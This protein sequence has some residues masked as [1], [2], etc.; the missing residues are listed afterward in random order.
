MLAFGSTAAWAG[1][2]ATGSF[3]TQGTGAGQFEEPAGVAVSEAT[4]DVYVVDQGNNRVEKFNAAGEPE[5]FSGLGTNILSG[6]GSETFS[7]AGFVGGEHEVLN[8]ADGIAV[9]NDPSNPSYE[10]IYVVDTGHDVVDK[11]SPAGAYLGQ[12]TETPAEE[13]PKGSGEEIGGTFSRSEVT[14][15]GVAVDTEGDLWVYAVSPREGEGFEFGASGAYMR[16]FATHHGTTPVLAA[17]ANVFVGTG[18]GNVKEFTTGGELITDHENRQES[19]ERDEDATGLAY[20][21]RSGHVFVDERTKISV[22]GPEPFGEPIEAFGSSSIGDGSGVAVDAASNTVYVPDASKDEVVIF[23]EQPPPPAPTTGS[24]SGVTRTT[25]VLNGDF[26]PEGK[27]EYYFSYD[28]GESCEGSGSTSTPLDNGGAPVTGT[29][30]VPESA[31][32][33]TLAVGEQYS[34]CMVAKN[35]FGVTPGSSVSFSTLPA[36]DGVNTGAAGAVQTTTATLTGSLEPNGLDAHYFFEYAPSAEY[37]AKK[38]YSLKSPAAPGT[39]AGEANGPV[40]AETTLSQLEPLST[41]D[42]RLVATNELGTTYGANQ[43]V[44]TLPLPP[45]VVTDPPASVGSVSATLGAEVA[46]QGVTT[47]YR[48]EY[49]TTTAYGS[50]TT[51]PEGTVSAS[52]AG[53]YVTVA[54]GS[55]AP[56]TEYHYRILATNSGGTSAGQDVTFTTNAAGEPSSA[57][58]PA[59][60]SLTGAAPSAPAATGYTNLSGLNPLPPPPAPKATTAPKPLTTAQKLAKALKACKKDRSKSKRKSCETQ[61]TK[62]YGSRAKEKR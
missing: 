60:F 43:T 46:P 31:T 53:E 54:V 52:P 19:V 26:D 37:E 25:A 18:N 9:D 32:V 50:S 44:L 6:T 8:S 29:S 62:K 7:L 39:D 51:P 36:V 27:G 55:L 47:T 41:Y 57:A 16:G 49:G 4:G 1:Y 35:A 5:D 42:Y 58:L 11:F 33:T 17:D 61:A 23:A 56:D 21:S 14:L 28:R 24:A 12:L 45:A 15:R 2:G 3:G 38:E 20:D 48:F 13:Y 10:D 30:T 59:G 22:Y 40:L 34:F